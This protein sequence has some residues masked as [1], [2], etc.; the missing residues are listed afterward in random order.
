MRFL[1]LLL[2]L[3]SQ[4]IPSANVPGRENKNL[5][6]KFSR[7]DARKQ[8]RLNR[9]KRKSD[10]LAGGPTSHHNN[11]SAHGE[12]AESPERGRVRIGEPEHMQIEKFKVDSEGPKKPA[13]RPVPRKPDL[14]PKSK[15]ALEKLVSRSNRPPITPFSRSKREREDDAYIAFLEGKLGKRKKSAEGDDGLD[16]MFHL[17]Q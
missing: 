1:R 15:T 2:L 14:K 12:H 9:K 3:L 13:S 6:H 10:F 7:K 17:I 5:R 4:I 11:W 16:G 8:E